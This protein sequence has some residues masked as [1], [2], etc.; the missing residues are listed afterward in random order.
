MRSLRSLLLV[1]VLALPG[2]VFVACGD[3]SGSGGGGSDANALV[4]GCKAYC[5]ASLAQKCG[6][7]RVTVELCQAQC[8][9]LPTQTKGFCE[10]EAGAFYQCRADD[11]FP[12]LGGDTDGDGKDDTF[13]PAPNSD[14]LPEA[15]AQ[16]DCEQSAGC[17]RFCAAG[18]GCLDTRE[19]TA[20][21]RPA[22]WC[23]RPRAS[24]RGTATLTSCAPRASDRA[25][26][27]PRSSVASSSLQKHGSNC[28]RCSVICVAARS[29]CSPQLTQ[30]A[31]TGAGSGA[32]ALEVAGRS[33]RPSR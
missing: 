15:Q 14:C 2:L 21:A 13:A 9:Y 26:L 12:C 20:R 23:P 33:A 4:Q 11:G 1:P 7:N 10:A 19:A 30:A 32:F 17:G 25:Q 31:S 22:S 6:D 8:S 28:A 16:L 24:A 18:S 27:S 29:T 5:A 3:D